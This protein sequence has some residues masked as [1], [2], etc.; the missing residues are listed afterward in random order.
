MSPAALCS[1][2]YQCDFAAGSPLNAGRAA[3]LAFSEGHVVQ[4]RALAIR[5]I[6]GA[7]VALVAAA[8]G[9]R[10]EDLRTQAQR[11]EDA[12]LHD[13][14]VACMKDRNGPACAAASRR[15]A[16]AQF[17]T[18]LGEPDHSSLTPGEAGMVANRKWLADQWNAKAPA[19][20]EAEEQAARRQRIFALITAAVPGQAPPQGPPAKSAV[21]TQLRKDTAP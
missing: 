20:N 17:K 10:A 6:L 5:V 1:T 7:S 9:S 21:T 13:Y 18:I 11:Q 16:D 19:P 4:A 14:V 12:A 15:H 3:N 2:H 8:S